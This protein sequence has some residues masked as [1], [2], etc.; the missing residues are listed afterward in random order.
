MADGD[1][2]ELLR[3]VGSALRGER[4][5]AMNLISAKSG[6]GIVRKLDDPRVVALL[7]AA[8]EDPSLRVRRA[9]ARGLRPWVDDNPSILDAAL[10]VY[11]VHT[12]DGT[13][14]HAGLYDT[15]TDQIWIPRFAA[16]KGHAALLSDGNT[17]WY[18]KFE[19]FVPGQAPQWIPNGERD[20]HLLL[21][22]IAEWSYSRQA[23]IPEYDERLAK[24]SAGE[25]QRFASAI[26]EFYRNAALPSRIRVH[27][28]E[29]GGGHHRR[30]HCDVEEIAA[31]IR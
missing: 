10:P 23:L 19:F 26:I 22:L 31:A 25:Q 8:L 11:A 29:G 5:R 2:D 21:Y 14:S 13:F 27:H 9:A 18:F 16:V 1:F 3:L 20:A 28:V 24:A 7:L 6:G 15:R 30:R 4:L 12:V 17:D